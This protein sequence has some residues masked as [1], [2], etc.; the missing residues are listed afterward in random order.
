M[1]D[2]DTNSGD[3]KQD[4]DPRFKHRRLDWDIKGVLAILAMFGAFGIQ[5]TLIIGGSSSDMPPW[6]VGLVSAVVAFY[7]G[8][9]GN[10]GA[11]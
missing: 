2:A 10:G 9:R 5:I 8:S 11:R 6:V 4:E 1:T 7:F 3:V